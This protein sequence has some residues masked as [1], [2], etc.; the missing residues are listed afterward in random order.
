MVEKVMALYAWLA[1]P[2]GA[3]LFAVLLGI[4]EALAAIPAIKA[5]SVFQAIKN[6]IVFLK[7]K[8]AKKA[9]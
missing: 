1:G 7:E 3:I 6:A 9:A 4:S 2:N 8:L 5:N